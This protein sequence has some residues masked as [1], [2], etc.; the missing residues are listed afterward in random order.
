MSIK[1]NTYLKFASVSIALLLSGV[2]AVTSSG[3]SEGDVVHNHYATTSNGGISS[4]PSD[5]SDPSSPSDPGQL[6]GR[7]VLISIATDTLPTEAVTAQYTYSDSAGNPIKQSQQA[8]IDRSGATNYTITD[9]SAP[10]QAVKMIIAYYDKDGN[11]VAIDERDITWDSEETGSVQ[12]SD[13]KELS[14]TAKL[15]LTADKYV[16]RPS[17]QTQ[18]TCL[19]VN[20]DGSS[21]NVTNLAA[22][23]NIY[24]DVLKSAG[25]NTRGLYKAVG[26]SGAHVGVADKIAVTAST[27]AGEQTVSLDKP[28]YVTEQSIN[29]FYL[30]PGTIDGHQIT[31]NDNSTPNNPDDD[32]SVV[33]YLPN[34]VK[35]EF[36]HQTL[37]Q[38]WGTFTKYDDLIENYAINE[39]P[40]AAIATF[41]S[42]EGK[43]PSPTGLDVT[44]KVS[45]SA[46]VTHVWDADLVPTVSMRDN[47]VLPCFDYSNVQPFDSMS[48]AS[49]VTVTG[50]YKEGGLDTSSSCLVKI[51]PSWTKTAFAVKREDGTYRAIGYE[52]GKYDYGSSESSQAGYNTGGKTYPNT[53]VQRTLYLKG[54]ICALGKTFCCDIPE[55]ILPNGKY[56]S[57]SSA[58]YGA[59]VDETIQQVE[60]GKNEYLLK[61]AWQTTS[62][63]KTTPNRVK[64]SLNVDS[65]YTEACLPS[66]SLAEFFYIDSIFYNSYPTAAQYFVDNDQ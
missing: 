49:T 17:E 40:I 23:S 66:F 62:S 12:S 6:W 59:Y 14:R 4:D 50:T 37:N 30:T 15:V 63:D 41:S 5:P 21:V 46:E 57:A 35:G 8:T 34:E 47:V 19:L 32:Y 44:D 54:V 13:P 65:T 25:E 53:V 11:I 52:L 61:I 43:G 31:I 18:L 26:H 55:E 38:K 28:I 36:V 3:C 64:L 20:E 58:S 2:V 48:S 24:S 10:S 1:K 33:V 60:S 27:P 39:L 29:G 22:F 16:L 56:P 51:A 45:F 9:E 42:E 7:T